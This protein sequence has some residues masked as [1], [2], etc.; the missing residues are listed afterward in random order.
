MHPDEAESSKG[1]GGKTIHARSSCPVSCCM[2]VIETVQHSKEHE[3]RGN[4]L[5]QDCADMTAF[6]PEY[7]RLKSC[8]H[9]L[10]QQPH[11]IHSARAMKTDQVLATDTKKDKKPA[12]SEDLL[13]ELPLI[14]E[15]NLSFNQVWLRAGGAH[16]EGTRAHAKNNQEL[17]IDNEVLWQQIRQ[18][19][20]EH[21]WTLA[22][23]KSLL[24]QDLTEAQRKSFGKH[25]E[26]A[27]C[28]AEN[29]VRADDTKE[30][31]V[32]PLI[33]NA[34]NALAL[35]SARLRDNPMAVAP[36]Q[37]LP[38]VTA[39][40]RDSLQGARVVPT[41]A[42]ET[43]PLL[44]QNEQTN[45]CPEERRKLG[46]RDDGDY[47]RQSQIATITVTVKGAASGE[48]IL[49]PHEFFR[50]NLP[51]ELK[52]VL[53]IVKSA[54]PDEEGRKPTILAAC[55]QQHA[56]QGRN[57][58]GG[59]YQITILHK[60]HEV[61][62][63]AYFHENQVELTAIVQT[64][65]QVGDYFQGFEFELP[66]ADDE[67]P[68]GSY[69]APGRQQGE[70]CLEMGC[71]EW[72]EAENTSRRKSRN[73]ESSQDSPGPL[74]HLQLCTRNNKRTE[75][76][77]S[78]TNPQSLVSDNPTVSICVRDAAD[79]SILATGGILRRNMLA[80]L[81]RELCFAKG[82]PKKIQHGPKGRVQV[83]I[84]HHGRVMTHADCPTG[85]HLELT[86]VFHTMYKEGDLR[87]I[88]PSE[89]PE[90][91]QYIPKSCHWTIQPNG[92]GQYIRGVL[93]S[94]VLIGNGQQQIA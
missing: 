56:E 44:P 32:D 77:V 3:Y 36:T 89:L 86:A 46:Q 19:E 28:T 93:V 59:G 16:L 88:H 45:A 14:N 75:A 78:D 92:G 34:H 80:T 67:I 51:L 74:V 50:I 24:D 69:W 21:G 64:E 87:T 71:P 62:D 5:R 30:E 65:Y 22:A 53:A 40:P 13:P 61:K 31:D 12:Q 83:E 52:R 91:P 66:M 63:H 90:G 11:G 1:G 20:S 18:M 38:L 73:Q 55:R 35:T 68:E 82:G 60:G 27:L 94:R 7:G 54:E 26:A 85:P 4:K 10:R 33:R 2:R 17:E 58:R 72:L 25:V 42:E 47:E 84:L 70:Y 8:L 81:T 48:T 39:P 43:A 41:R 37:M 76:A 15:I 6:F 57:G 79:G 23:L 29:E 9:K 49:E